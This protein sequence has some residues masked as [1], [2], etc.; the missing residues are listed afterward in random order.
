M[1]RR[2]IH[3]SE[4]FSSLALTVS[5]SEAWL[6]TG[7]SSRHSRCWQLIPSELWLIGVTPAVPEAAGGLGCAEQHPSEHPSEHPARHDNGVVWGVGSRTLDWD[8]LSLQHLL[9]WPRQ[10]AAGTRP[11]VES[12]MSMEPGGAPG[13]PG[14][15][16]NLPWSI[17]SLAKPWQ[18]GFAPG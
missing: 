12:G 14:A 15:V 17:C 8:L 5:H 9:S 2:R 13:E 18:V 10:W 11:S 16:Q 4:R 3:G 6:G 1:R 7:P